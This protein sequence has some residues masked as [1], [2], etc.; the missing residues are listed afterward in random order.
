LDNTEDALWA[1]AKSLTIEPNQPEAFMAIANLLL[2]KD[3]TEKALQIY[4]AA[5][6]LDSSLEFVDLFI[7]ICYFYLKDNSQGIKYLRSAI[8][9]DAKARD[10]FLELCPEF[11]R[12]LGMV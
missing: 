10:A 12:F 8:N 4:L 1:Y 5:R 9:T 7:A 11:E 2:E 6:K 3:E